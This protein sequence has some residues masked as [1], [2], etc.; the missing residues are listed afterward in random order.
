M[1]VDELDIRSELPVKAIAYA[2]KVSREAAIQVKVVE[3]TTLP[4]SGMPAVLQPRS[5]EIVIYVRQGLDLKSPVLERAVVHELTRSRLL[6]ARGYGLLEPTDSVNESEK[7]SLIVLGT[8]VDDIIINT[9][10]QQEGYAPYDAIYMEEMAREVRSANAGKDHYAQFSFDPLFKMR[11]M[12]FRYILAWGTQQYL[13]VTPHESRRITRFLQT[14]AK[15]Y[16]ETWQ[17]ALRVQ[18]LFTT[19]D[20]FTA[21]GHKQIVEGILADWNLAR[22]ATWVNYVNPSL[23]A[24]PPDAHDKG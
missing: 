22:A 11:F 20:A 23:T 13:I 21:Q 18:N 15:T 17:A 5:A 8:M 3:V 10:M 16:S 6:Y 12:I 24:K 1:T 2:G 7:Q 19:H 4:P 9:I 14:F